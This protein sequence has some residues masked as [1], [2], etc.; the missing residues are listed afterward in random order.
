VTDQPLGTGQ[1]D[2]TRPLTPSGNLRRRLVI[3]RIA[4]LTATSAAVLAVGVLAIVVYS[5]AAK[6]GGALSLDFLTKA[7]PLAGGSGGGIGPAIAGT[8]LIVA[9]ATGIAAPI[10]ILVALYTT[11]FAGRR[12]SRVI[13]V[14]L[15]LLNGLP[16]IVIGIFVF[17]LIVAGHGQSGFAG[18]LA[19]SII[20]LP[21]IAR[22]TQEVLQLVPK[23]LSDAADALGVTRWRTVRGV[24]LPNALG[25]ILTATV[26]AV[27]RAAGETAPLLLVC[28][29]SGQSAAVNFFGKA[30]PNIPVTI[31]DLS[32]EADPAGFTRAW[33]AALVLLVFILV[34]GLTGRILLARTRAKLT[35]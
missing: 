33:G 22:S 34:S 26:L 10:G 27:A 29:I 25:G 9:V 8:A 28:S 2:H 1:L 24:L 17:G 12:A 20:M 4:E 23:T 31:F 7:E 6:G 15:D 21:L 13:G 19:L 35:Q 3:N 30:L 5:V 32:E 18:S 16:S 11:E 14:A